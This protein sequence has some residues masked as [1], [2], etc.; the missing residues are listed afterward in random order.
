MSSRILASTAISWT[1]APWSG[2]GSTSAMS[3]PP[4]ESARDGRSEPAQR[5][6]QRELEEQT[7]IAVAAARREGEA[8]GY[9][10]AK[11]ELAPLEQRLQQSIAELAALRPSLRRQAERQVVDLALAIAKRI[12]QRQI[13]VDPDA[14]AGLVR[15]AL[16]AVSVRDVMLI[17][18]HPSQ[19][20]AVAASLERMGLPSAVRVE[21]DATLELG[22]VVIETERGSIDCSVFT[23]LDEIERGFADIIGQVHSA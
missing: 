19:H 13:T 18:V 20:G 12:L 14:V 10:K 4:F 5:D 7:R 2:A 3:V 16:D 21:G 1:P 6:V 8:A 17:R 15:S 11:L 22:G 9:Q 23:Q